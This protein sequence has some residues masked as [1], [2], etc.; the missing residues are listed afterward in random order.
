MRSFSKWAVLLVGGAICVTTAPA[1]ERVLPEGTTIKLLLLRQKSVQ[2]ELDLGADVTEKIVTFTH[3]Q[4]EAARKALEM[5]AAERKQAFEKLEK[6]NRKFLAGTLTATQR[7]RLDQIAMQF[8]P[9]QHLLTTKTLKT[10]NLTEEQQQKFK[11]LQKEA[12]KKLADII[13]AKDPAGRSE[14]LAELH[15]SVRAS[16]MAVLTDEQKAQVR[17]I[18]GPRF[19]GKIVIEE[20][21]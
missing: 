10:L 2:K 3:E 8:T 21:E 19:K 5:E 1:Q 17:E 11:A 9:L 7:K 18:A 6:Q 12:H 20:P 14:K 15:E 13:Y 4:H 16:I